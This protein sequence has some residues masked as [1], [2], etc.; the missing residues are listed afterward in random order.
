[1]RPVAVAAILG[2]ALGIV[3]TLSPLT[4]AFAIVMAPVCWAA[5]RRLDGREWRWVATAL[6]AAVGAR[7]LAIVV[8]LVVTNPMRGQFGVYFPDAEFVIERSWWI[9][10]LWLGVPIGPY[11]LDWVYRPYG[12]SS[13]P[14]ILAALQMVFGLAP[15]GVNLVSVACFIAGALLLFHLAR[16]SYGSPAAVAGLLLLLAWPTF[17][18]WSV[19]VLRESAQFFCMALVMVATVAA[20][21]ARSWTDRVLAIGLA[22][23]GIYVLDSLRAGALIMVVLGLTL[24]LAIRLATLRWWI[25]AATLVACIA[26]A[27]RVVAY[28]PLRDRVAEE[29]QL[30]ASRHLGHVEMPG[31]SFRS[32]D[33][34][35]YMA[36]PRA[37]FDMSIDEGAR[38]LIRSAAAFVLVPLP[39]QVD[40]LSGLAALPQQ[41]LWYLTLACALVGCVVG[42]R[43]DALVTLLL[44]SYIVSGLMVIGPNNG[45]IGTLVRHRD[46]VVPALV[47]LAGAGFCALV[48][49]VTPVAGARAEAAS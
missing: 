42:L 18:A 1:M 30:A 13:F 41:F 26:I 14:Y 29:V 45:N 12:T 44:S 21:R 47:W 11:Y 9:R 49:R 20:I 37:P 39:W 32:L 35:F 27:P 2:V 10:N 40:S 43:R 7:L 38:F 15:Y 31:R 5:T 24:G 8:L 46:M 25:A 34:R 48:A 28:A 22:A 36:G 16:R 19:S 17:F 3:Y 6:A 4:V 33:D 23:F